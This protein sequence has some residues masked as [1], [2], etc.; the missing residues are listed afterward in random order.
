MIKEGTE[1]F[2][3]W[4]KIPQAIDF[5]VYFFNVT[6]SKAVINGALP[7]VNEVGPYIYKQYREKDLVGFSADK[8][9]VSYRQYQFF[10]FD[11][12]ASAPLSDSDELSLLNVPLL[13][14]FSLKNWFPFFYHQKIIKNSKILFLFKNFFYSNDK[15]L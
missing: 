12:E 2:D 3:R 14:R 11:R 4:I 15:I 13:V 9:V 5:K 7:V 8:T 6:N 1:Q 10:H